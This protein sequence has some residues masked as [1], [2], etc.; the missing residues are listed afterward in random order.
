MKIIRKIFDSIQKRSRKHKLSIIIINKVFTATNPTIKGNHYTI[1]I[2]QIHQVP[3]TDF[4]HKSVPYF[5][6]SPHITTYQ[7]RTYVVT[8]PHKLTKLQNKYEDG[9]QKTQNN[10][11]DERFSLFYKS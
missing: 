1:T 11:Q 4:I 8:T 9:I 7:L 6:I 3:Q 10:E 2:K 5:L